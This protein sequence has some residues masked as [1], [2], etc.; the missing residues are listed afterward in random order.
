M[1]GVN[2]NLSSTIEEGGDKSRRL[3]SVLRPYVVDRSALLAPHTTPIIIVT[4]SPFQPI[5]TVV[6]MPP[7]CIDHLSQLPQELVCFQLLG[8]VAGRDGARLGQLCIPGRKLIDT[9]HYLAVSSRGTV[10]HLSQD[11]M[12]GSSSIKGIYAGLEDCMQ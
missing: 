5:K 12:R 7:Q 11:T 4:F 3:C 10:P 6:E 8:A 2:N 9:P 1:E